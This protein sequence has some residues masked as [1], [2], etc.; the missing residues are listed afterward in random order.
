MATGQPGGSYD[1][2]GKKYA[3]FFD[4]KGITLELVPT[5]GAEENVAHLVDRK[6]PVQAAFVQVGAFNPHEVTGVESRS[7]HSSIPISAQ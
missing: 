2:L 7:G 3:A 6:D 4:K 5:K 1:N